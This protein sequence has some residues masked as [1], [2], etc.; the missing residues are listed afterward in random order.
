MSFQSRLGCRWVRLYAKQKP[1]GEAALVD[2]TRRRFRTPGW[3]VWM[4]SLGVK[5]QAVESPVKG[6][7]ISPREGPEN[8][9]VVYYL[10]GGGYISGSAKSCRPITST[11]ARQLKARVFGLDYR[12][13]PE[14]R[15]PAGLDDAVAGYRWL[16]SNGIDPQFIAVVGDSAGGGMTLALALRLRDLG[17]PLPRCLV[18]LSPWTDMTGTSESLSSNSDCDSMF[19]GEDIERY[20]AAYLGSHS[21]QDPLASPLLAE[22]SGLPPLLIQVGRDEVLLDDARNFHAKVSAASGSSH[23]HIYET[24]P[25]GWHYGAPFLP[26]TRQALSEVAKFIQRLA[27]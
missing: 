27:L 17:G 23:L 7:W 12:L 25:H 11:L 2:F 16:L 4:H 24:V 18:C 21:R 20:A 19:V 10:H 5:I 8:D 26:E 3:L 9:L 22:V 6:E 14:H 1:P 13:A 15:F